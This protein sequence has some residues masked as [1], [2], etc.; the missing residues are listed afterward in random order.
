MIL[1]GD[2]GGTK[3]ILALYDSQDVSLCLKKKVYPSSEYEQF[4]FILNDFLENEKKEIDVVS[5]G[6]AGPVK[7][8]KC[9]TTN[10]PWS[11]DTQEIKLKLSVNTV[12]LLNDLEST[13]WGLLNLSEEKMIELNQNR[14]NDT[15]NIAVIAAGTGLGEALIIYNEQQSEYQVVATEGGH[16]D[17]APRNELEIRLLQFLL[18][19]YPDHVS[20]ERV[21]C[22]QG[23][24]NI[25]NF[26]KRE[27][28]GLESKIIADQMNHT[29][30]AAVIGQNGVKKAD[31]LCEDALNMFVDI[32]AAAAGNLAL[33][34]LAKGGVILAGGI[35]AKILP[36]L[37]TDKFFSS[38]ISKGRYKTLLENISIKVCIEP[39]ASL[40]GAYYFAL[41]YGYKN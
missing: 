16:V 14:G 7:N 21:V 13:A 11:L 10:L 30:P 22:G 39:E 40:L 32:Y 31:A 17:F 23:L 41:K 25:Y 20:Y 26:L 6:V 38:F 37:Q 28:P 35:A 34:C 12:Y 3:T 5:I 9:I 1:A 19:Y 33:K 2:I 24:V 4:E 29:D 27:N 36:A 8:G 18:E 15:G